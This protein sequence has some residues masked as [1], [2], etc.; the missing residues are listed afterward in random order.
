MFRER[1]NVSWD[2]VA[3]L[4]QAKALLK[5][6]VILPVKFP[7]LFT[8]KRKPWKGILLYGPPGT[9]KYMCCHVMRLDV[10]VIV[11]V[12]VFLLLLWLWFW[13]WFW[14]WV[15][16]WLCYCHVMRC[17]WYVYMC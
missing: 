13:L 5:E 9:C 4:E 11:I 6:A 15:W 1:P 12:V 3:G 16:V 7:Q 10:L 17:H 8:G 2:E 14:L